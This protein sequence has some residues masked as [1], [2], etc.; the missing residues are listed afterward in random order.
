[1]NSVAKAIVSAEAIVARALASRRR[2]LNELEA[3]RL[4]AC[5]GI[6]VPRHVFGRDAQD[7]AAKAAALKAPLVA[8]VVSPEILHKS[9]A[10]GVALDLADA[11]AVRHAIEDMAK[12]P[13]IAV[14]P[15]EGWLVEEMAPRG[16]EIVIG[17]LRDPRFGPM[18]M[19]GVGGIF[20]E[21]FEDI[22]FRI[23]PI[24]ERD[25]FAMLAE[26]KAAPLLVGVRGRSPLDRAAIVDTLLKIGG[27]DG[28]MLRLAGVAELDVNPIVVGR[29]GLSAVDARIVL[30]ER[31][32]TPVTAPRGAKPFADLP[33]L[34]RFRPLFEPRTVAVLGASAKT[35]S[36][37][38]NTFIR[39]MKAFGY[40][41]QI[42]PIHPQADAIE[43]L[44]AYR[45]LAETPEPADYAFVAL[46][47]ERIPA[48]LGKA[49]GRV[50]FAQV[51]SS[52]FAEVEGGA[53]IERQ[54]AESAQKGGLRL[55]GPNCLGTYS[56]RGGLTFPEDAPRE[57]GTIGLI[58]QSGGL[59]T[60][61]IRRGQLKGLRY[62]GAA[63]VG[64]CADV[65]PAD[66]LEFYLADPQTTA[67]GCYIEDV[68]DGRAFYELL[69]GS[70]N[71]KPVVILRGG[72]SAQGRVAA[73]SHT[74]A[75][76]GGGKAWQAL[77]AQTPS[78]EVT[79]LDQLLD[80]LLALQYLRLR[81]QRPSRR[82]VMFGNGGGS[83]VLGADFFATHGLEVPPFS[84]QARARF[85]ALDLLP[86]SSVANPID[87]PVATLQQ[88]GGHLAS[89]ILD[90][91]YECGR[92]D[93]IAMHLNMSSF[94]G[95]GGGDPIDTIFEI[96]GHA[97][98]RHQ[99]AAHLALA[100]RTDG[101]PVLEE[102]KHRYRKTAGCIGIPVFDEIPEMA[103]AMAA[104]S[105]LEQRISEQA[106]RSGKPQ[107][108]SST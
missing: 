14:A 73:A 103:A 98:A 37:L 76:A 51:I 83:S 18:V 92:P 69:R 10:G 56:P 13:D 20:V 67:I 5:F 58:S 26:L 33:V 96:I 21:V 79:T 22:S 29:Q 28:V 34:E 59:T 61:M 6:P 65:D 2:A 24:E 80:V 95:R 38:A 31:T 106:L 84:T 40:G 35:S 3:K 57:T 48:V 85:E 9:D 55:I 8:K 41:G 68:K 52:G 17:G 102:R 86:G 62:S 60:N 42:Y 63:T 7:A 15:I 47:A 81:P 74:G 39:R 108:P 107:W 36:A 90:L 4:L 72:R 45:S 30:P 87:T 82:V 43:E 12:R 19:I 99:G 46:A 11:A 91:I 100:L 104:V 66:L 23:C 1:M 97:C 77:C 105:H 75:L 101:D 49:K 88:N 16:Q 78:V 70:S 44:R 94:A 53:A 89:V 27:H 64:N 25:A 54:L 93:I 71:P 32:K 50:R